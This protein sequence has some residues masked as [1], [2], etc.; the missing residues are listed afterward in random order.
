MEVRRD[1][2]GSPSKESSPSISSMEGP[3]SQAVD[4]PTHPLNR[5]LLE[6]EYLKQEAKHF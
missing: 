1:L 5:Y 6:S 2:K 4:V 3:R